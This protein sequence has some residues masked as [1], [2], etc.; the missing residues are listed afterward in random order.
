MLSS[1]S[2]Q[3]AIT[4]MKNILHIDNFSML[5]LFKAHFGSTEPTEATRPVYKVNGNEW[6]D[7]T[8]TIKTGYIHADVY[9]PSPI[10]IFYCEYE[11][12]EF[13]QEDNK[14]EVTLLIKVFS[15]DFFDN[16][17][18]FLQFKESNHSALFKINEAI[19]LI[20]LYVDNGYNIHNLDELKLNTKHYGKQGAYIVLLIIEKLKI[21]SFINGQS[22]PG[23]DDYEWYEIEITG[24]PKLA[25]FKTLIVEG[26]KKQSA[27]ARVAGEIITARFPSHSIGGMANPRPI[28][29]EQWTLSLKDY[30]K[31]DMAILFNAEQELFYRISKD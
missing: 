8:Q 27:D 23:R 26:L 7:R 9:L 22:R 14:R 18:V 6:S 28:A 12:I 2:V 25:Y 1:L 5:G 15:K 21:K 30:L 31:I 11:S 20:N 16:C 19:N 4:L 3:L 24:L 10:K 17:N 29:D 13:L